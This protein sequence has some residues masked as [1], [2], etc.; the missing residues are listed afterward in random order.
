[1]HQLVPSRGVFIRLGAVVKKTGSQGIC[2]NRFY[3]GG[4]CVCHGV[5]VHVT[6]C[7]YEGCINNVKKLSVHVW[8]WMEKESITQICL[9]EYI[10]VSC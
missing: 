8:A 2:T 1:M 4:G 10:V 3:K 6:K 9:I 7:S 5:N